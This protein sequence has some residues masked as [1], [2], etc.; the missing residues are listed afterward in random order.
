MWCV[1]ARRRCI[2]YQG[3][4][5]PVNDGTCRNNHYRRDL[6]HAVPQRSAGNLAERHTAS[7]TGSP[8]SSATVPVAETLA[9]T[10]P[11]VR[12]HR[13]HSRSHWLWWPV[14]GAVGG[15]ILGTLFSSL[16]NPTSRFLGPQY[17][18]IDLV[19]LPLELI[20]MLLSGLTSM[21]VVGACA[22]GLAARLW[23]LLRRY[24]PERFGQI[25]GAIGGTA[26][27][28]LAFAAFHPQ[29]RTTTLGSLAITPEEPAWIA[30][31]KV[32]L[33]ATLGA[34]ATVAIAGRQRTIAA[35]IALLQ[36]RDSEAETL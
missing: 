21:V 26:V 2:R 20:S 13:Q 29:P 5:V 10:L 34:L 16:N 9:S 33:A 23:E 35:R 7:T 6:R 24:T 1:D 12:D 22:G 30:L 19:S 18:A 3:S 11:A 17:I 32:I 28:G 25:V 14:A 4:R 31:V 8:L 27:L 36:E 15:Y